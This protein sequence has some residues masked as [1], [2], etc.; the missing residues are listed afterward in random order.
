MKILFL[1]LAA[2]LISGCVSKPGSPIAP[3][4]ST[5]PVKAASAVKKQSVAIP[6]GLTPTNAVR[7]ANSMTMAV[8]VPQPTVRTNLQLTWNYGTNH[9]WMAQIFYAVDLNAPFSLLCGVVGTNFSTTI[10]NA[11]CG[12]FKVAP[13]ACVQ[14][15]WIAS[16]STNVTNYRIYWGVSSGN[17]SN[18]LEVGNVT[19]AIVPGLVYGATYYF[20][21]TAIDVLGLESGF[22][23][24]TTWTTPENA[25]A[26]QNLKLTL[27]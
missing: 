18:Q 22:S 20:A 23:N 27:R 13:I 24:E 1:F 4:P 12:F 6:A 14:L 5:L 26:P 9:S 25:P 10:S 7:T 15:E 11:Q 8:V 21:A 19:N 16:S 3:A 2:A 17:Y